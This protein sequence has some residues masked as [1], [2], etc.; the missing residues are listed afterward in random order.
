[1]Y[2]Y[3]FYVFMLYILYMFCYRLEHD[4]S[5]VGPGW[6]VEKVGH[7][8]HIL[9]FIITLNH[10]IGEHFKKP[11]N[12]QINVFCLLKVIMLLTNHKFYL[13]L[14]LII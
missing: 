1:M 2:I 9:L 3:M 8:H 14:F 10:Y 13:V 5:G 6:F 11:N 7:Q 4:N 12:N